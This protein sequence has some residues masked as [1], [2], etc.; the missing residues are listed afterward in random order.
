MCVT[1]SSGRL[2]TLVLL[3]AVLASMLSARSRKGAWERIS[4]AS[5]QNR[6]K[7]KRLIEAEAAMCGQGCDKCPLRD[8][9]GDLYGEC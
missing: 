4:N 5:Q 8:Y 6:I 1:K 7:E 2:A 9:F 3:I